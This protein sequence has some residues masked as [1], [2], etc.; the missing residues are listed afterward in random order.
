MP[1]L[2]TKVHIIGDAG[3]SAV[4]LQ[5]VAHEPLN[6]KVVE[7]GQ[8]ELMRLS[9]LHLPTPIP[10]SHSLRLQEALL[11]KHFAYKTLVRSTNPSPNTPVIPP[12]PPPTL[13]TFQTQPTYTIGRRHLRDN[14]LSASQ[15]SY[16][17]GTTP[18]PS[19]PEPSSTPFLFNLQN[20]SDYE[21]ILT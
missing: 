13:L 5:G 7:E 15:I 12:P 16:L 9:H 21:F 17:T 3:N 1:N 14:P 20:N 4:V 2:E 6:R 19:P 18:S 11:E 10:Y 8:A